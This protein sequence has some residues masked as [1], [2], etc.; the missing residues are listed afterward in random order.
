MLYF[1]NWQCFLWAAGNAGS[2]IGELQ[3]GVPLAIPREVHDAV[4]FHASVRDPLRM[5]DL[6]AEHHVAARQVVAAAIEDMGNARVIDT[7]FD[8]LGRALAP[9]VKPGCNH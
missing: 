5:Q 1:N 7:L 2:L 3:V 9:E 6:W 4:G 8:V